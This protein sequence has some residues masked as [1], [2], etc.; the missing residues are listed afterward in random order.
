MTRLTALVVGELSPYNRCGDAEGGLEG[1]NR[2]IGLAFVE[3][4]L[5][6]GDNVFATYRE[7][8]RNKATTVIR[9]VFNESDN[10]E[11]DPRPFK[12][13]PFGVQNS[14]AGSRFRIFYQCSFKRVWKPASG[15]ND[16]LRR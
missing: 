14:R 8:S 11:A 10:V 15:L 7:Q 9:S 13:A 4:L 16:K 12:A 1:G 6:R 2:G 3:A 5:Q